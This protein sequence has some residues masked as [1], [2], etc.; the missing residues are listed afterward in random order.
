MNLSSTKFGLMSMKE[1]YH[2][3]GRY[4]DCCDT[5]FKC[6]ELLQ[7]IK[8]NGCHECKLCVNDGGRRCRIQSP[9]YN[10]VDGLCDDGCFKTCPIQ[11]LTQREGKQES[12][13]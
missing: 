1:K 4:A 7:Y 11:Q 8:G 12:G 2:I 6:I 10:F 13:H 9:P 5:A 3:S